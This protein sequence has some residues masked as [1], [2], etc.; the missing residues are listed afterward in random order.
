MPCAFTTSTSRIPP[1]SIVTK[2]LGSKRVGDFARKYLKKI[3]DL[4]NFR[5]KPEERELI[6]Q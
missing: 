3:Y 5:R 4:H 2:Y 1:D 6:E